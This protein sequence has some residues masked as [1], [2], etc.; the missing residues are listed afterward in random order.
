MNF[1]SCF[2]RERS[3]DRH[4]QIIPIVF[5]DFRPNV[6]I[7][8][9]KTVSIVTVNSKSNPEK[10]SLPDKPKNISDI[11]KIL[12]LRNSLK[13]TDDLI[14]SSVLGRSTGKTEISQE[15]SLKNVISVQLVVRY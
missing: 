10:P 9:Q 15:A 5:D 6:P 2:R 11:K 8:Q 7:T 1:W 3:S 4:V 12:E 13:S 14:K